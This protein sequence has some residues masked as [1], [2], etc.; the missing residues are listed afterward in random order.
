MFSVYILKNQKRPHKTV[1]FSTHKSCP[2]ILTS[3]ETSEQKHI[4]GDKRTDNK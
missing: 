2:E 3:T 1:P 4:P